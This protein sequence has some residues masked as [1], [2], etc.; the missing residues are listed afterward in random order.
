MPL[1]TDFYAY[2]S[3]VKVPAWRVYSEAPVDARNGLD[4][5]TGLFLGHVRVRSTE[6]CRSRAIRTVDASYGDKDLARDGMHWVGDLMF[7]A[8]VET[9]ADCK[10]LVLQ[11]VE[12][13][14]KYRCRDR[15]D[16]GR[17]HA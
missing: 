4:R 5:I 10:E 17:R 16:H 13:G 1:I 3:Y 7:E 2:D 9:S 11:L 8:D 15:P 12:A 14:I 6:R